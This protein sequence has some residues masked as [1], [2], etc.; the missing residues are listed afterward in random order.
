[1]YEKKEIESIAHLQYKF[2]LDYYQSMYFNKPEKSKEWETDMKDVFEKNYTYALDDKTSKLFI[3]GN[4]KL[5][6]LLQQ[7]NDAYRD[8]SAFLGISK[9]KYNF[10]RFHFYRPKLGA[11]LE[12]I[13]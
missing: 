8:D 12:V 6:T 9:E 13:R 7:G 5:V 4:G 1:M 10:Y 2:L 11:P 3:M